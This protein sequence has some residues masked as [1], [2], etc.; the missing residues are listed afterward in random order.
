ME[1]WSPAFRI[2]V[3]YSYTKLCLWGCHSWQMRVFKFKIKIM[4]CY[5]MSHLY[6][7]GKIYLNCMNLGYLWSFKIILRMEIP[8]CY[9]LWLKQQKQPSV[10]VSSL[11]TKPHYHL[12][13]QLFIE[14][15]SNMCL[16]TIYLLP[17]RYFS[18]NSCQK[19]ISLCK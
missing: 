7:T 1:C 15:R 18:S 9:P 12:I 8:V 3:T 2:P 6:V 11:N 4:T 5:L 17:S 19:L 16:K 10:S 14:K 13:S